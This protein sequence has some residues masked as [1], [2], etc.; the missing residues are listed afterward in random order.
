MDFY[1]MCSY[2]FIT[3]VVA[4]SATWLGRVLSCVCAQSIED[5]SRPSFDLT[6]AQYLLVDVALVPEKLKRIPLQVKHRPYADVLEK[7]PEK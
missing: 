3:E 1:H 4:R 6:P 5:D 7:S 2:A